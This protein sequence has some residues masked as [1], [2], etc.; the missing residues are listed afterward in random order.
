MTFGEIYGH[1]KQIAILKSAMAKDRIAHAY[2]FYGMEGIGKRTTAAVFARALNCGAED[3]PCDIC[4]SCRKAEHKNHSDIIRML[5]NLRH[6]RI[7]MVLI[8]PGPN[9]IFINF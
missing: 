9:L 4:P 1:G 7:R 5:N 2:L 6:R 8:I 3:P